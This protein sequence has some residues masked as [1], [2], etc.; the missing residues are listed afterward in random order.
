VADPGSQRQVAR[1]ELALEA[2]HRPEFR[3][4]LMASGAAIQTMIVDRLAARG[5]P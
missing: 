2:T 1:H 3:Q 5:R 4:V